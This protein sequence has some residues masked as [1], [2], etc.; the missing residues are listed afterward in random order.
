[1]WEQT[2]V[3]YAPMIH[4]YQTVVETRAHALDNRVQELILDG[5]QPYGPQHFVN[6]SDGRSF[7]QPMVKYTKA[8][9]Q[10]NG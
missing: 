2:T 9:E 4:Q 6:L 8:K 7:A 3:Q 10:L 1:M 5:W